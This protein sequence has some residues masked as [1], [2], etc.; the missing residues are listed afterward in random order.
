MTTKGV[1]EQY[2]N[3]LD[4]LDLELL[5]ASVIKKPR[6]FVLSYPEYQLTKN[7]ELKTKNLIARR[8]KKEPLAYIL[9]QKEF[10]GLNF[11]V[12]KNTLIPR[13][14]TELIVERVSHNLERNNEGK[15][16]IIDIGTGSGNIIISI[17]KNLESFGFQVSGF[18]FY[19]TDISTGALRIAK[20]N[21]KLNKVDKKIKFIKGN[22]LEPI[23]KSKN[24]K[25]KTKNFL[26][27]AN[28]PYLSQ[29]IYNS[30]MPDVKNYEPKSALL[31][32]Q[33]GLDH[34]RK[35]FKQI[36]KMFTVNGLRFTVFLEISPEQKNI[37][38]K[39]IK[40]EFPKSKITFYKDLARKWR[41]CEIN[42]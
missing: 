11:K 2:F 20:Q 25:L 28:L 32:G 7:Q 21:A 40:K 6:E 31:S 1:F 4:R 38:Q 34:Y 13:P 16:T 39:V 23:L 29:N 33:D 18:K 37:L 3:K 35:L 19:G 10:Y 42:L 17:V 15:I 24:Y 9:G 22:L 14:E 36:K 5:I 26:I 41:V 30:T 27:T 8:A 12:D